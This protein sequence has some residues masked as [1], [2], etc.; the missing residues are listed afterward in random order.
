[1]MAHNLS[2]EIQMLSA[3]CRLRAQPKRSA[4]WTFKTLDT[5][6][7]RI[8][9]RAGRLTKPQGELTLTM[10][11]NQAVRKDLLHFLDIVKKA[12]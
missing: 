11:A 1:M 4:A 12:A 3:S 8:I 10:S 9:Q 2:R 5:L 7:H 6:R